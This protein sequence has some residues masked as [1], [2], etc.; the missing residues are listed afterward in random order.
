VNFDHRG[1]GETLE[2]LPRRAADLVRRKVDVILAV[3]DGAEARAARSATATVPIVVAGIADAVESGLVASQGR[4]GGNVTGVTIPVRQLAAKQLQ[5]LKETLP[6]LA[7]VAVLTNPGNPAHQ[8]AMVGAEEAAGALGLR[9]T[10]LAARREDDFAGAFAKL[11]KAGGDA[12][13]V[14]FDPAFAMSGGRL[15]TLALEARVPTMFGSRPAVA[16][17]GLMSFAPAPGELYRTA[18]LL[19]GKILNGARPAELPVEEPRTF[20]LVVNL[21]TAR[22]IGVTIPQSILVR[23]DEVIR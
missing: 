11:K 20:E 16:G 17:A 19:I 5:L 22:A 8:P 10:P 6:G 15:T 9:L 13:L 14:L 12:L 7:R 4:P 21:T 18:A 23:A 3:G 2:D 1:S